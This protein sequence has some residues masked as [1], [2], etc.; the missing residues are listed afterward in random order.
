VQEHDTLLLRQTNKMR[1]DWQY[2]LYSSDDFISYN[3]SNFIASFPAIWNSLGIEREWLQY[4]EW[5][6]A[7][8]AAMLQ[9]R[10]VVRVMGRKKRFEDDEVMNIILAFLHTR[11][12]H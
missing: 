9:P 4:E 3:D 6:T 10:R 12:R 7:E 11:R 8:T 1:I 5:I 2:D